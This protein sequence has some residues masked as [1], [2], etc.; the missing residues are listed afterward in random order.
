MRRSY[1][2]AICM[3]AHVNG[4]VADNKK[5]ASFGIPADERVNEGA[6]PNQGFCA[7]AYLQAGDCF[8]NGIENEAGAV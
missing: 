7:A 4:T 1:L 2:H 6:G 8:S 3:A 5:P